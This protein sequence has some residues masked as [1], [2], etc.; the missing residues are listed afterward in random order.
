MVQIIFREFTCSVQP[1]YTIFS[2]SICLYCVF[3]RPFQLTK[4]VQYVQLFLGWIDN[5]E[6]KPTT[7]LS[8]LASRSDN[9]KPK[10]KS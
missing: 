1:H 7:K 9:I 8:T 6:Y 2:Y 4:L 10:S 5:E 3:N